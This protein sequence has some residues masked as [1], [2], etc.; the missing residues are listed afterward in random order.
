MSV[1]L[2]VILA[3][4]FFSAFFSGIEIAYYQAN[5]LKI[6]LEKNKGSLSARVLSSFIT[7][8]TKFITNTL[9]GNN[10]AL[11]IYGLV[12][13]RLFDQLYPSGIFGIQSGFLSFLIL[14]LLSGTIVLIFAEFFPKA[15]FIINPNQILKFIIIPFQALYYL[16]YPVNIFVS[17]F[18]QLLFRI[19]GVQIDDSKPSFD[20]HDL[21]YMVHEEDVNSDEVAEVDLD[22]QIL[23][24]A[25][26]LPKIKVRECMIPRPEI[27][28]VDSE[29][30]IETLKEK[31]IDSGHSKI[32]VY[33]ET[34]DQI[35][36]YVHLVD[37]LGDPSSIK[38]LIRPVFIIAESMPA[39]ELLKEFTS[40]NESIGLVVDEYGGTAGIVS[41]EDVLEEIFGEI[42]DEFDSDELREVK[43]S[44]HEYIFST[45]LEIDYLNEKY[46]FDLPE[47]DFETLGGL[48]LESYQSIPVK[49]HVIK[50]DRFSFKIQSATESRI[51]EVVMKLLFDVDE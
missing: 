24:N 23:K 9:V 36:G 29:S 1:Y 42:E 34:I 8:P 39:N 12:F 46:G 21:F 19:F 25:I 10:V 49:N 26:E 3:S 20:H 38:K 50:I 27:I 31:F 22:T 15:L 32:V 43:V 33:A 7:Y 11:V 35:I 41:I 47:G 5:R 6:E 16:L 2:V 37:L 4:L 30:D 17:T 14:T 48:I 40:S 18:S 45:R 44:E 28:A 51:D 13:T